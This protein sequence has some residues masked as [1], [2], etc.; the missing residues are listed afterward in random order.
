MLYLTSNCVVMLPDQPTN[1]L[2]V[3]AVEWLGNYVRSLRGQTT[4]MIVSHDYDFLEVIATDIIHMDK[5]RMKYHSCGFREFQSQN[6]QVVEALPSVS[7]TVEGAA[8]EVKAGNPAQAAAETARHS[9]LAQLEPE[10][11]PEPAEPLDTGHKA[12]AERLRSTM[13][14]KEAEALARA[15]DR[16][17]KADSL[18]DECEAG[19]AEAKVALA[20]AAKK[21]KICQKKND[22]AQM[23]VTKPPFLHCFSKLFASL[24]H[25]DHLLTPNSCNQVKKWIGKKLGKQWAEVRKEVKKFSENLEKRQAAFD[26]CEQA[27]LD[28]ENLAAE[29]RQARA[30]DRSFIGQIEADMQKKEDEAVRHRS[31]FCLCPWHFLVAASWHK[32][33]VTRGFSLC[34]WNRRRWKRQ[35]KPPLARRSG[36]RPRPPSCSRSNSPTR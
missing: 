11:E 21:L 26:E 31:I 29:A 3:G 23:K 24:H 9:R 13:E 34:R 30:G 35:S 33:R 16:A 18:V 28:A 25:F 15:K 17:S 8:A 36:H 2:D 5:Q 14:K 27:V 10:P 1:H 22:D 20:D 19:L 12:G 4:V 7:R 6:P 32:Q